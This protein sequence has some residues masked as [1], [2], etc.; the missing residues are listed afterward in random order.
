MKVSGAFSDDLL[1]ISSCLR[2]ISLTRL[3]VSINTVPEA[4]SIGILLSFGTFHVLGSIECADEGLLGTT[5]TGA[6]S[7][8]LALFSI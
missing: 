6:Q 8:T 2:R 7:V 4:E 3:F 1:D 5:L